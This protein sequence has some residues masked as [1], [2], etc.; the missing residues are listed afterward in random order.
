MSKETILGVAT[1]IAERKG[2]RNVT[3]RAVARGSK[4]AESTVS[5]Y[6]KTMAKLQDAIMEAAVQQSLAPIVAQGLAEG[7]RIAK[8]A[9]QALKDAAAK[10]LAA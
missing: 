10:L 1:G 6:F 8:L 7:H 3:R 5:Y 9:P 4:C 2:F